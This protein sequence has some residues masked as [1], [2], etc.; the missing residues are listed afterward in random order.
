MMHCSPHGA[1]S[2]QIRS[3]R[4]RKNHKLRADRPRDI[5][6]CSFSP[7]GKDRTLMK[8]AICQELFVDWDWERQCRFISE[9]GYTGIE[10]APFTLAPLVTGVSAE[11]RQTL[12]KQAADH[13]LQILGLHW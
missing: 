5:D 7:G 6:P 13:G 9:V 12:K 11:R 10:V 8:F 2:L 1:K 4:R 3:F